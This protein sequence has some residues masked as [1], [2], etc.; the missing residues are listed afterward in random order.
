MSA[1]LKGVMVLRTMVERQVQLLKQRAHLLYDYSSVE[2]QTRETM[3]MLK[4]SE[5]TKWVA[6]Q[7][8]PT[9]VDIAGDAVEAFSAQLGESP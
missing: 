1:G 7:V 6:G 8:A 3:E 2:D 5:V 4:A 9:T